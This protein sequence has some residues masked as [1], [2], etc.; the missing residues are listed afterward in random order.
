[1]RLRSTGA[2]GVNSGIRGYSTVTDFARFRG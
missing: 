2:L 1:M